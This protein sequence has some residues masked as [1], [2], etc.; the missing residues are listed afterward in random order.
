[1][2]K[3]YTAYHDKGLNILSVS[4]DSKAE[5]WKE[6]IAKDGMPWYHVSSLQGWKEPVA[7]LY[8][9][10]AVPQNLLVNAK[11]IIVAKNLRADE[12]LKKLQ[13]LM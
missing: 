10:D 13:E 5:N 2:V 6:A 7:I 9:V 11:G 8:G 12:L 1:M 4:L 3:A